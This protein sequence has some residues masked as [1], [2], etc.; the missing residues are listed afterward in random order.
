MLR[1]LLFKAAVIQSASCSFK[2]KVIHKQNST[3]ASYSVTL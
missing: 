1:R 2:R 3:L